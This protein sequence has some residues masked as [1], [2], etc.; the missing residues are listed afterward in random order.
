M[1]SRTLTWLSLILA[2]PLL[3]AAFSLFSVNETEYAIRT[4]FGAITDTR[5]KPG[6]HLKWP[7]DIVR[8][9]DRRILSESYNGET[10]LTNDGRNLIVDFYIKWRV[11]DP[12]TFYN[13]VGG[14]EAIAG[15]RLGEIVKDG[16]KSV[17]AQ[18]TLQQIVA[19]E[20]AA[21]TNEMFAQASQNAS[22]L[23]VD[24]VDVRVERIDLPDEVAQRV[25][26]SMKQSFAK[27]AN[28]LRAEG[29]QQSA[30]IKANADRQRTVILADAERDGL[31][32]RG[33]G[34]AAAAQTFAKAYARNPEFYAFWRS[35]QAYQ[36]SLGKDGDLLVLTPD[37]EFFRYLK[38]PGK[39]PPARR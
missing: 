30:T 10:F 39:P 21:F 15:Q 6:I 36:R 33:E 22:G 4:R 16:I 13:A 2:A 27:I 5:Y 3:F 9:Y 18:R 12:G 31:R 32:T 29:Q 11:K 8:K 37:G 38:D 26:E 24:L 34:D 25:Y 14:S 20:R 28:Q 19:A 1:S 17:V 23:G 35:L 7:W